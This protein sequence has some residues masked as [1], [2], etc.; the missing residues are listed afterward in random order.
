M[1]TKKRLLLKKCKTLPRHT[2]TPVTLINPG[3]GLT[4]MQKVCRNDLV[5]RRR[6]R[7]PLRRPHPPRSDRHRQFRRPRAASLQ[8]NHKRICPR[9]RRNAVSLRP[10]IC[11]VKPPGRHRRR[12]QLLD[13]HAG[14]AAK[15]RHRFSGPSQPPKTNKCCIP[16]VA[17]W[18]IFA[19]YEGTSAAA[20]L[21]AGL[22]ALAN[23]HLLTLNPG[24]PPAGNINARLYRKGSRSRPPAT[25]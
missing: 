18:A 17:A 2:R 11:L 3:F 5:D 16:D 22:I 10:G 15:S 4:N 23:E 6:H 14:L 1:T 24:H 12:H 13:R 19:Q 20:P 25:T 8:P 7:R 9:L 21:W